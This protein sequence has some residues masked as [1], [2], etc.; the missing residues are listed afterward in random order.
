MTRAVDADLWSVED[1]SF[2]EA[3]ADELEALIT[4]VGSAS[5]KPGLMNN[6][7]DTLCTP[8]TNSCR[9]AEIV[10]ATCTALLG[11]AVLTLQ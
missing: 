8:L 4:S 1:P 10:N 9:N 5:Q 2:S 7:G 6:G 3:V 11:S